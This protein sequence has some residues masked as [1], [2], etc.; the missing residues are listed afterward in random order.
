MASPLPPTSGSKQDTLEEGIVPKGNQNNDSDS[1][2]E[3]TIDRP[4]S[5]FATIV[6]PL[7]T[8]ERYLIRYNLE[9][10]GLRRVLP[11]ETHAI[12]LLSYFQAFFLW[13]SVNLAA[14]N[15]TL[16]MLAP[17]VF[18]LS[19]T[20]SALCAVFGSLVGSIAVAWIST[21]GAISGNRTMVFVRYTF[22]WWPTKL[23][24]ILNII[25]QIGYSL[26][27]LVIAGQI[28]SAISA[29]G[30]LNI[31]V[32]IIVV[33]IICW[34]IS[35]FGIKVF[36]IYERYAW[37]PQIIAVSILYGVSAS[38]YDLSTPSQGDPRTIVGN[39]FSFFSLCLSAAITWSGIAADFFVYYPPDTNVLGLFTA[40]FLGLL[41]S[42]TFALIVGIGLAS[43]V[44]TN[45]VYASVYEISQGALIVQG[46]SPLGNF[47]KFV[48]FVI[49]LSLVANTIGPSYSIGI[50]TQVLAKWAQSIPRF[51]WNTCG[52]I[53]YTVLALAGRN[54]LA[55]IFTNFLALMGYWVSIWIAITLEEQFI[56]RRNRG[57]DWTAWNHAEKLPTGTSA[58]IAFLIGYVGAVLCMAQVWYIGPIAAEV[59]EYGADVSEIEANGATRLE[60]D[61]EYIAG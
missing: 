21:R 55:E 23:I 16:G 20:D 32:G 27:D 60:T 14:N 34:V 57:F 52:V 3:D 4:T 24:V 18:H 48:S 42:F 37:F 51:V 33:A 1:A 28:L 31:V 54:S 22:G 2:L 38:D 9:A 47:G 44:A 11:Q 25:I 43:A 40:S 6:Q 49:L 46:L 8:F 17:T 53:I 59:G 41:F 19:F 10:R 12:R 58:L 50:D 30:N 61:P 15:I 29:D 26:I 7:R 45:E 13:M 5:T 39:R 36:H 56:F 35:T